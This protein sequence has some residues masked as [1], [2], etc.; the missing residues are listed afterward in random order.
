[1]A[2]AKDAAPLHASPVHSFDSQSNPKDQVPECATTKPS[3][4]GWRASLAYGPDGSACRLWTHA[5]KA[6]GGVLRDPRTVPGSED[7]DRLVSWLD[8]AICQT[9][10]ESLREETDWLVAGLAR[11]RPPLLALNLHLCLES[12]GPSRYFGPSPPIT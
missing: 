10:W 1:M 6:L 2:K 3:P 11:V 7:D 9:F 5:E 12:P 4:S 8:G